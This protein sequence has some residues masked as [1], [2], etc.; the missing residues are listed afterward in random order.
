MTE[1]EYILDRVDDQIN[2]YEKKAKINKRMFVWK[3]ILVIIFA[4]LIPFLAGIQ[5]KEFNI[6]YIIAIFGLL[7]TIITGI[8]S[9]LKLEKKWIEY[10]TTVE[11]VKHEKFLYLTNAEPYNIK[12]FA[13][14]VFVERIESLIS[15]E[16]SS[17]NKYIHKKNGSKQ[18]KL[19]P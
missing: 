9:M 12:D 2:W 15:K 6:N 4:A 10:R 11:T 8:S 18:N 5:S 13:F 19:S 16:N 17:W 14:S 1:K 7:I 3:E